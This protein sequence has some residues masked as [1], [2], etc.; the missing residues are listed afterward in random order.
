M[1]SLEILQVDPALMQPLAIAAGAIPGALSRYYLIGAIT[2]RFGSHFPYGTLGINLSGALL[3]GFFTAAGSAHVVAPKLLLLLTTGF[4]GAYT[5]FSTYALDTSSLM[6]SH[7]RAIALL[8][9]IESA[10]GGGVC[11]AIGLGIGSGLSRW[12]A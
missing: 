5:T 11:L 2:R 10:I 7:G 1:K 9:W 4:V 8:Y 3:M 12:L 6:R